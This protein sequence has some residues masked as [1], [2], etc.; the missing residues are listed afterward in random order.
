M[1]SLIAFMF[2][3]DL[4]LAV[5]SRVACTA[6]KGMPFSLHFFYARCFDAS[7]KTVGMIL[8]TTICTREMHTR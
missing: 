3:G 5:C 4:W 2:V 7:L 1:D 8:M 6:G